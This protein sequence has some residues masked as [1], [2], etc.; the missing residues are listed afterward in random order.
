MVA[1]F[2]DDRVV[3]GQVLGN[4]LAVFFDEVE[5]FAAVAFDL[6]GGLLVGFADR[7]VDPL[8]AALEEGFAAELA[9]VFGG[10]MFVFFGI[11]VFDVAAEVAAA[12]AAET[13]R[14]SAVGNCGGERCCG[15]GLV[16]VL[17]RGFGTALHETELA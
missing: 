7:G 6:L 14:P 12:T 2:D 1:E 11:V 17:I 8:V 16:G 9:D 5:V 4:V 10:F 15:R 3:E 13:A